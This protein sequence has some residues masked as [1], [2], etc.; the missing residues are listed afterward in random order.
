M[1]ELLEVSLSGGDVVLAFDGRVLEVF[2]AKVRGEHKYSSVRYLASQLTVK[3]EGPDRKG[4]FELNLAGPRQVF[5][6]P[7]YKIK[8]QVEDES[9]WEAL[10]PLLE[11]LRVA[12]AEVQDG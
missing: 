8:H 10:A 3:P 1:A 6:D 11:A 5:D 9:E 12:G 7:W 4:R 2:G